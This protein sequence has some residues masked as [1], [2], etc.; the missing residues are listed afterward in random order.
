TDTTPAI[1]FNVSETNASSTV[2]KVDGDVVSKVSG[3]SL[4]TLSEGEHTLTIV[5]T[6]V[7]GHQTTESRI[8]VINLSGLT[9][10]TADNGSGIY[11]STTSVVLTSAQGQTI[12]YT[13]NGSTPYATSSQL[14]SSALSISTDTTLKAVAY[15]GQLVV[16]S[17]VAIFYYTIKT[18]S[19]LTGPSTH[20]IPIAA[21]WN[22][23]SV[24]KVVASSTMSS[25]DLGGETAYM[26]IDSA[27][28]PYATAKTAFH[29]SVDFAPLYG[30]VVNNASSAQTLTITYDD[31]VTDD[32]KRFE[33]DFTTTG[34]T[35]SIGWYSV[36]VAS[37]EK[38]LI[39][40][41]SSTINIDTSDSIYRQTG[42]NITQIIDYT[43]NVNSNSTA[44]T[45][46]SDDYVSRITVGDSSNIIN[47]R[48]TRGYI[49]YVNADNGGISGNQK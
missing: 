10:P 11:N 43:G 47:P 13:T 22:I 26:L 32:S 8:F 39:Q 44:F 37:P 48:E 25:L 23:F 1:E 27:W 16:T 9:A 31:T 21:G 18:G 6:D 36:G 49:M 38:S 33:R 41:Y 17:P 3:E 5:A 19:A 30:Y 12:Y 40:A 35:G 15:N 46:S 2:V 28:V 14:Y 7:V 4:D 29:S 42:S 20:E 34:G 24:P 45:A